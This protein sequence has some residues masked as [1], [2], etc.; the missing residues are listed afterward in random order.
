MSD[1]G[2]RV[3]DPH[4]FESSQIAHDV[5]TVAQCRI[6]RQI[7][8]SQPPRVAGF[9]CDPDG[10]ASAAGDLLERAQVGIVAVPATVAEVST[11]VRRV[12]VDEKS[13]ANRPRAAP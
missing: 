8:R 10:L 6:C 9:R 12:I 7:A 11:V 4:S 13:S 3:F 2:Q 1:A 5:H